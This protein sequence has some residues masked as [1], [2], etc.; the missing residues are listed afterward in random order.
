MEMRDQQRARHA[1]SHVESV[2]EK[3][4]KEYKIIVNDFGATVLRSGLSAAMAVIERNPTHAKK[5]FLEHL[6]SSNI[7]KL[8]DDWEKLPE[9]VRN[10]DLDDYMLATRE[11]LKVV[12][13]HKR[14]V[15]ALFGDE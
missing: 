12:V 5:L 13:W 14:A 1:Y 11:T 7:P 2:P 6:A 15:Q 10:L 3:D 4:R 9:R 8:G